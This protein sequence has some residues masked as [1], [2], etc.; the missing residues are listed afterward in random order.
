M[1]SDNDIVVNRRTAI[2]SF[3][4]LAG[5]A[6]LPTLGTASIDTTE[7]AT[8]KRDGEVLKTAT[9]AT[10]WYEQVQRIRREVKALQ[11][12]LI[13]TPGVKFI[14]YGFS[15]DY[16]HDRTRPEFEVG[17]DPKLL[18]TELPERYSD[19]NIRTEESEGN[20]PLCYNQGDYNPVPGG[21]TIEGQKDDL[22]AGPGTTGA[23]VNNPD[24][25][26]R[27][28]TANHLTSSCGVAAEK[29]ETIYQNG[30][31]F[32]TVEEAHGDED[33]MIVKPNSDFSTKEVLR[34][35]DGEELPISGYYTQD[36]VDDL[37]CYGDGNCRTVQSM[38]TTTG[39][40][41][42][43]VQQRGVLYDKCPNMNG[44]GLRLDMESAKGDSGGLSYGWE[45]FNGNEYAVM[46]NIVNAGDNKDGTASCNGAQKYKTQ[47]GIPL[48]HL[49]NAH[50]IQ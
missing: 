46:L 32:G 26:P 38:G 17:Y 16:I 50:N 44:Y 48:F 2:K 35:G 23:E 42:G 10:E 31:K 21:V 41:Y 28:L 7:I 15:N 8:V 22:W 49:A 25:N 47:I 29:G 43:T 19:F 3:S 37:G 14:G 4:G 34:R 20:E 27:L 39:N 40:T 36:G 18:K 12:E 9:V 33:W 30:R 45:K 5:L 13:D 1:S 24:G 11:K 6:A